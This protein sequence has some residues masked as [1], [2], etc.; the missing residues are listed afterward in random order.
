MA[1][2][3]VKVL[4]VITALEAV[5]IFKLA[6]TVVSLEN[7]RFASFLGYCEEEHRP[8]PEYIALHQTMF[9]RHECLLRTETRANPL[10]HLWSAFTSD[11]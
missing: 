11:Y 2:T 1:S 3:A 4:A 6:Q 9:M 7:Y 5:M 8:S 10:W